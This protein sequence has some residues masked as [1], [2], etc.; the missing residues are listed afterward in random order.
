MN[1]SIP[2]TLSLV[3]AIAGNGVI[4]RGGTLP[5]RLGS[6]LKRFRQL[7]MGHPLIMGRRTFESIGKPL[8]G[9]DSIVVT[10]ARKL[11]ERGALFFVPSLEE[12]ITVAQRCARERGVREAFV[13][14]GA[15]LFA[16]ALP[17]AG[18]VYLTQVHAS[19]EGDVYWR[20]ELGSEW[21]ERSRADRPVSARDEFAVT[22]LVLERIRA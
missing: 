3:V 21:T 17:I 12:A 11:A 6:D 2:F 13:I 19:P 18:R 15:R 20:P 5:W 16:Q 14:G 9:R 1:T 22:D 4:G 7:T 10:S 8:D